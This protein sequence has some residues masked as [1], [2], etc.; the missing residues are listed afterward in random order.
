VGV[1][2]PYSNTKQ[3]VSA[4]EALLRK[5]PMADAPLPASSTRQKPRRAR[6]LDGEQVQRLIEDYETGATLHELGERFGIVRQTVG[7]ILKRHGVVMR[8]RGLSPEQVDEAVRLYEEG[9]SL[10][11]VGEHLDVDDMTVMRRLAERGVKMRPRQG[12]KR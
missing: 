3:Q 4:L 10:A 2:G 7:K 11:R 5:L 9:W 8:Q 6:Q 12:G 1:T